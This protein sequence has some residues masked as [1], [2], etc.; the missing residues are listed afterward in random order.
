LYS[1]VGLGIG[2][3][4]AMITAPF[5][6]PKT[7]VESNALV[8]EMRFVIE[9]LQLQ[10]ATLKRARFGSSSE[11][12]DSIVDQMELTLEDLITEQA[13]I[14]QNQPDIDK[15]IADA[16]EKKKPVR[17][18]LPEHLPRDVT[19]HLPNDGICDCC[20]KALHK[21]GEDITE[22]LDYVPA[23]FRVKRH[24][25]LKMACRACDII[26]QAPAIS[27]PI[28]KGKPGPGL[29]A[30]VLVSKYADHLPLYRQSGMYAREGVEISR[31]TM[32][33]WVGRSMELV[34][35]L[36]DTIGKHVI[37][38][39]AIHTDDTPVP[40][41][42][43]G[44]GK[45]KTGRIWTYLRDERDWQGDAAPAAYYQYSPDRKGAR[46]QDHLKEYQGFL[47]ADG[48]AGYEKLYG[49]GKIT[50]VACMAHVRR[51]FVDIHKANGSP[52][53]EE[54][55]TRIA[56]LYAIEK[57]IRRQPPDIKR[58]VRQKHAKP[59]FEALQKWLPTQLNKIPA[60]STLA[61]A[62]RYAIT[63]LKRLEVYLTDG[64]LAIDNNP[65]ERCMRPIALGRKNF[66]FY[67]SDKGGERAAAAYTLLETAKLNRINPQ[68]YLT[69]VL[70]TIADHPINRIDELLPWNF[71]KSEL[72]EAA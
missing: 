72:K 51:K 36:V 8:L 30:N 27:L 49:S 12:V 67:G 4:V 57:Q 69:W 68:A 53:A 10:I 58:S 40:V 16:E 7:L 41:Q 11:A 13:A 32:A 55:I 28:E 34:R 35:P 71:S 46:P 66:L 21:I 22:V 59:L 2:Y 63:R 43:P 54:A 42:A 29:L 25:R 5:T 38:G 26:K 61:G 56:A 33:D 37:A 9:K 70:G 48:Y 62:I 39:P 1:D 19:E 6:M 45:T 44:S 3:K 65:A 64:R 20:G 23:S 52:L 60:K 15:A 14:L 17:K 50:E 31:N 47:H 18:P 24:V